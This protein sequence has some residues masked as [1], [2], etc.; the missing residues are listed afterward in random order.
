MVWFF[1][2]GEAHLGRNAEMVTNIVAKISAQMMI[3]SVRK[4]T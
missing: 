3:W 1:S 4:Q 2:G